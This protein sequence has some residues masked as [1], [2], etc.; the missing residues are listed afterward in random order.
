MI[1]KVIIFVTA[2]GKIHWLRCTTLS[3]RIVL[4]CGRPAPKNSKS[5]KCHM[6]GVLSTGPKT[7]EGRHRIDDAKKVHPSLTPTDVSC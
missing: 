3:K 1:R 7:A 6:H 5:Q 4:Q 2:A